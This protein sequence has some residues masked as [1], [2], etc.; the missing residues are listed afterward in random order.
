MIFEIIAKWVIGYRYTATQNSIDRATAHFNALQGHKLL[1]VLN[2][3]STFAGSHSSADR[4]KSMISDAL[5]ALEPKGVDA[6]MVTCFARYI[7]LTNHS[8]P[9]RI[10]ADDRRYCVLKGKHADQKPPAYYTDVFKNIVNHPVNGAAVGAELVNYLASIELKEWASSA[11]PNTEARIDIKLESMSPMMRFMYQVACKKILGVEFVEKKGGW[12]V[13]I[14]TADLVDRYRG[15]LEKTPATDVKPEFIRTLRDNLRLTP[16]AVQIDGELGGKR[17]GYRLRLSY[18]RAT[19]KTY[20]R[21]EDLSFEE[22][23]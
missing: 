5:V 13:N 11:I 4:L 15:W 19:F 14:A 2:E 6:K 21:T 22:T 3:S 17:S 18:L 8:M 1:I 16:V 7:I 10:E 23:R 20:L 9:V 12:G